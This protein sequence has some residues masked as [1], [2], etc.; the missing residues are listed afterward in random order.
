MLYEGIPCV[1][2][3]V[4]DVGVF[5]SAPVCRCLK[6]HTFRSHYRTG[7]MALSRLVRAR[8]GWYIHGANYSEDNQP[9]TMSRAH[10]AFVL[11][12]IPHMEP[13]F[14]RRFHT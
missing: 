6:C 12:L 3:L 2:T 9:E 10:L 5:F 1:C 4:G 11:V 13:V 14:D 8:P 7:M